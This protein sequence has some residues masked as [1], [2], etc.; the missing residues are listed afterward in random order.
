MQEMAICKIVT[1]PRRGW[2]YDGKCLP[3]RGVESMSYFR[4]GCSRLENTRENTK[5]L[6]NM[7]LVPV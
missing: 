7:R 6:N 5:G 1:G 3:A 4:H 2:F